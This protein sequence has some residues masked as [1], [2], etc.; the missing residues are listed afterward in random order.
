M[1]TKQKLNK[2][3][4][5]LEK[6]LLSVVMFYRN[7]NGESVRALATVY[8]VSIGTVSARINEGKGVA[9]I[10]PEMS[11]ERATEALQ[12]LYET[13]VE[14]PK[15][16]TSISPQQQAIYLVYDKATQH[17]GIK[18]KEEY[19]IYGK[20][21]GY[22]E[23][24]NCAITSTQ[25]GYIRR[26][27][28][29]I[30]K[31]NGVS[32]VFVPDWFNVK[33]PQRSLT[34][35]TEMVHSLHLRIEEMV[36]EYMHANNLH[37]SARYS[38]KQA[39]VG[40]SVEGVTPQSIERQCNGYS[41]IVGALT[42]NGVATEEDVIEDYGVMWNEGTH[43]LF[44]MPNGQLKFENNVPKQDIHKVFEDLDDLEQAGFIY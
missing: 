39:L 14:K 12:Q 21:F 2:E 38:V 1:R 40:M 34:T 8:N 3:Q 7:K 31:A 43:S 25:K 36:D 28:R 41:E 44:T 35:M 17:V 19:A 15:K 26:R 29:E 9:T 20:I 32:A 11:L 16:K 23:D 18:S 30:A 5:A 10:D 37:P 24:G 42:D 6:K 33:A 27:V 22:T 4:K 13:E